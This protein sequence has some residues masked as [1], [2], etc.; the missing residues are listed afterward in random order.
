LL[1]TLTPDTNCLTIIKTIEES[2]ISFQELYNS[3]FTY[4][5]SYAKDLIRTF[6]NTENKEILTDILTP[7]SLKIKDIL[8]P[9]K[10]LYNESFEIIE[11]R[12]RNCKWRKRLTP[13][14][15]VFLEMWIQ[16]QWD[17]IHKLGCN[18]PENIFCPNYYK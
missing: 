12:K 2:C 11:N 15:N 6:E 1:S 9:V 14:E 5:P 7:F 3:G 10:A 8:D 13:T 18:F 4:I 17:I 16:K